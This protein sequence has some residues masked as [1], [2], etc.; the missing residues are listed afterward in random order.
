VRRHYP[1]KT[2]LAAAILILSGCGGGDKE[3]ANE[4]VPVDY[5]SAYRLLKQATFGPNQELVDEV[6]GEGI[7]SW[8]DRQLTMRSAYDSPDDAHYTHLERME[9]IATS[10]DTDATWYATQYGGN[11]FSGFNSIYSD[12][13][14]LSVW[15]ENA[16]NGPD[17]LRQRV[18]Y[19]LSQIM[20]VSAM[21][22]TLR[23]NTEA[24][25]HFYDIL[26]RN[27]FGNFRTL[28]GEMA[29][30]PAMG[31]YLSHQGNK[32]AND[33]TMTSPD[34]NFAR[35]LMQLF[36]L[37]IYQLNLDGTKVL[38][39][40][41]P[42]PSYT[43]EDIQELAKVMT[44][45][46]LQNNAYYG[47]TR[48][49]Y[50]VPMEFTPA[51]H[52][53]ESKILLGQMISDDGQGGDMDA[54]LDVLFNH[55]NTGPFIVTQL[56]NRMVTSNPTPAYVAR[57]ASVFNDNGRG[58][59]GDLAAV[60]KAILLDDEARKPELVAGD[61]FGRVEEPVL[62]YTSYLRAFDVKPVQGY[63]LLPD[64]PKVYDTYYFADAGDSVQM[65]LGQA[66]TRAH[67]VFN[68]Y[69]AEYVPSDDYYRN[70]AP[71]KVLPEMMLQTP[72]NI[73]GPLKMLGWKSNR[74]EKYVQEVN[75]VTH[76]HGSVEDFVNYRSADSSIGFTWRGSLAI[77]LVDYSPALQAFELAMDGDTNGDYALINDNTEGEDGLTPK[78][79]GLNA[80]VDFLE[81]RVLGGESLG[82]DGRRVLIDYLSNDWFYN[83]SNETEEAIRLTFGAITYIVASHQNIAVQ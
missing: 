33:S 49:N 10:I 77:A 27:A 79:R 61:A 9:Q 64:W 57:V 43:Q 39:D 19:A 51:H 74:N 76:K 32:K 81:M 46:D 12:E 28:L 23:T 63:T 16:L 83:P 18:A 17:Q 25:A 13:F 26:A 47:Y 78:A 70:S 50:T 6:I 38:E 20:V 54:A 14:Q 55:D 52:Q 31:I 34:E 35:E 65:L 45:W 59:R 4:P 37:G 36:T 58:V 66:P 42:V 69:D 53:L 30:S 5:S 80:L 67:H 40:G 71:A 8:V 24:I 62:T 11:F 21:D 56:I 44:G 2:A 1:T 29:R 22:A 73:A 41:H 15:Y 75:D 60:V 82:D 48:G 68:F 72:N 3:P 7:T